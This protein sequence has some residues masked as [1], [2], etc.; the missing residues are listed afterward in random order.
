MALISFYIETADCCAK[1]DTGLNIII[2]HSSKSICVIKLS[3]GQNVTHMGESFWIKD[4]L[5][6]HMLF[7]LWLILIFS[8]VANFAQHPLKL[9]FQNF[10]KEFRSL[11]HNTVENSLGP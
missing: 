7:E 1:F 10:Y 11:G 2:R 9:D 5:I 4:N 6:T 8:P 3:F